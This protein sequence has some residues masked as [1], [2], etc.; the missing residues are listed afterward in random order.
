M[1]RNSNMTGKRLYAIF[2]FAVFMYMSASY[3]L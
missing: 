2:I 1:K 3:E